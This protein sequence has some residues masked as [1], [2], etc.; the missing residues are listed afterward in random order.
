LESANIESRIYKEKREEIY[1]KRR[2]IIDSTAFYSGMISI[3]KPS[4]FVVSA[5]F[6]NTILMFIAK[7]NLN[8]MQY[9]LSK[10]IKKTT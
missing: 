10:I 9:F 2:R 3:L 4:H 5:R 7:F 8:C 6:S 1:E